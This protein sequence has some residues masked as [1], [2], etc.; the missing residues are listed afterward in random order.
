MIKNRV[1]YNI[2]PIFVPHQG[3]PHQCVFCNQKTVTGQFVIPDGTMV[4]SQINTFL[5]HRPDKNFYL[6]FYGLFIVT[7]PKYR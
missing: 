5:E 2:I 7:S 6:A 3:C 1:K 4:E